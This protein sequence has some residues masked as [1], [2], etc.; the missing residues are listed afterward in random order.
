MRR[1]L[2]A[3][4]AWVMLASDGMTR[5][6]GPLCV[7]DPAK[8]PE[9]W[10]P[11]PELLEASSLAPWS[12]REAR[13]AQRAV[14]L[15]V[16]EMIA[17]FRR[18]P[19]AV[20]DLWDDSV[21]ALIQVTYASANPPALDAKARAAASGNLTRLIG[22]SLTRTP[23]PGRLTCSDFEDLLPL[24]VFAHE[25]YPANDPRTEQ[26]TGHAN[27]AYRAC[28]SLEDAI[29]HDYRLILALEQAPTEPLFDLHVWAL[30][31]M[32]AEAHPAIELPEETRAF[33]P[34]L[35]SYFETYR[36]AGAGEFEKG[37][38]D[39]DFIAIADLAPHVVH[40]MTA[41][42]RFPLYVADSPALYRFHREN[43]YA[44]MQLNEL[45]LFASLVDTLRQYGCTPENDFQ[46]RDGTRYLIERFDEGGERW[47]DF[48]QDGE[49]DANIDDYGLIHY[50]WT[51]VLGIRD[52]RLEHLGPVGRGDIAGRWLPYRQGRS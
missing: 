40:I 18:R 30:W 17:H 41:V 52:R 37:A 31:F 19:A 27:A 8:M 47:M 46:V 11:P 51:A 9:S 44:V 12:K 36:F 14:E 33:G 22:L 6:A 7:L 13:Q 20:D 5:E 50:P 21:E 2:F 1:L 32:A 10:R 15:G 24:A 48:R 25:L 45:D 34:A 3:F 23:D 42:N 29:G 43:F 38:R 49:T 35:W 28:D 4:L 16:D 39:K 26:I